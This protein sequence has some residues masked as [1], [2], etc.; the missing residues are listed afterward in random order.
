MVKLRV[1]KPDEKP[2]APDVY[3]VELGLVKVQSD[4][5]YPPVKALF[6]YPSQ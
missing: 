5:D 2:K 3:Q 6:E 1:R 4:T